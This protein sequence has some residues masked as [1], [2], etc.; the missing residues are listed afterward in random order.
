MTESFEQPWSN[1]ESDPIVREF[2]PSAA[3]DQGQGIVYA[4]QA[5]FAQRELTGEQTRALK[6][7]VQQYMGAV[8][9]HEIPPERALV[10]VKELARQARESSGTLYGSHGAS[11]RDGLS[12][13][14]TAEHYRALTQ[15]IINWAIEAYYDS[16]RDD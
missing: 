16:Q 2:A 13:W 15:Q 1:D 5:A 14:A 4:L 6:G 12:R 8:R 7:A 11:P 3:R 10:F 9:R